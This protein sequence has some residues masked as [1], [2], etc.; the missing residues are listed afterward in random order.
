MPI[1]NAAADIKP[2]DTCTAAALV[3]AEPAPFP[4]PDQAPLSPVPCLP[5][6]P[7]PEESDVYLHVIVVVNAAW[8]VIVCRD[9]GSGFFSVAP[10]KGTVG[11][12]GKGAVS[13]RP[14]KR[15]SAAPASTPARSLLTHS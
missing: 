11:R 1:Q 14:E 15:S 9:A 13:A 5:V 2:D 10:A 6:P 8:R 7:G 4:H 12:A 3:R